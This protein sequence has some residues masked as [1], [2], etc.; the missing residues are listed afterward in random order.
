MVD[1]VGVVLGEDGRRL[2][3]VKS[4]LRSLDI[5]EA[6]AHSRRPLGVTEIAA[7]TGFSKTAAYNVVTTLEIRGMVR[8]DA[9]HKY[10][11]GWR[12]FQLGELARVQSDLS[13]AARPVV[14]SLAEST[15]ETALLGVL[16]QNSVIYIEKAESR[17]SIRMVEAPGQRLPLHQ[18]ATG[19]VLLAFAS[20]AYRHRY[21][22]D[23]D[24]DTVPP[25]VRKVVDEIADRGFAISVQDLDPDLTTASVPVFGHDG[26]ISAALTVAGPV[27]RLTRARIEEFL[28]RILTAAAAIS[29]SIGGSPP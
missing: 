3:P 26:A 14:A 13:E 24:G 12:L 16:D 7:V 28:P 23:S 17:R 5:L 11:L 19:L 21:A 2:R 22:H 8:R 25:H 4:L 9:H 29:E 27:S 10:V 1:D 15:G 6:L 18:T 20:E